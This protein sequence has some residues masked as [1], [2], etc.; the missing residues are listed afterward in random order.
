MTPP[1]PDHRFS[2]WLRAIMN[3]F[4]VFVRHVVIWVVEALIL[5]WMAERFPGAYA[6]TFAAA[7]VVVLVLATLNVVITPLILRFAARLPA[8]GYPV[9]TFLL[10]GVVLYLLDGIVP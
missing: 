10:N 6:D 5:V 3:A 8:W 9:V 4:G 2:T 7:F 1:P